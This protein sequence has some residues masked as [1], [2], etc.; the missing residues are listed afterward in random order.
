[1]SS[2]PRRSSAD[3]PAI[4]QRP[5]LPRYPIFVPTKGRWTGHWLTARF[6]LRDQVPFRLVVEPQEEDHYRARFP[7]AELL[8]LPFRDQGLLAVRN[9]IRDVSIAEGWDRHWQLDDNISDIRRLYRGKR[10]QA[11][12]GIAL[13]VCED[14][15][16]RYTN[17]GVSGLNYEM[18]V[19]ANLAVPYYLNC[20]VYSCSLIWNRMPYHWRLRYNDDTD[21]CLQVL[22]GGLC[23]VALNVFMAKKQWTMH[24]GG[25]NTD[26]LY[27]GDGRARMARTLE[28]A[29]PRVVETRRRF[30]RPQH[31]IRGAWSGFDTPLQRRGDIDWDGLPAVDEYGL[32]L[33]QVRDQIRSPVVQR[34]YDESRQG[35][36]GGVRSS[37]MET[38]TPVEPEPTE[39]EPEQP[40]PDE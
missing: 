13:R 16:D 29:W 3:E 25:G 39:P 36:P 33:V 28:Q 32:Q 30:G 35:P 5:L 40:T 2:Q 38:T 27:Q 18:F 1:M 34:I 6:L 26:D 10:I 7:T 17:I 24:S 14:F 20:H 21:L 8:V 11:H 22:A 19:T 31:A 9:W 15:T 37:P 23:T 12:S 4:V